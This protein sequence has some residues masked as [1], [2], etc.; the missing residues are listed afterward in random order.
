[1]KQMQGIKRNNGLTLRDIQKELNEA[2][3]ES[4]DGLTRSL[5]LQKIHATIEILL[6]LLKSSKDF[7]EYDAIEEELYRWENVREIKMDELRSLARLKS[8]Y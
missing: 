5:T 6:E 4:Q 1:M 2:I 7:E 8:N 3:Q